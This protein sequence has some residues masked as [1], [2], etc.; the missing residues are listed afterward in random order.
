MLRRWFL[1]RHRLHRQWGGQGAGQG[2]RLTLRDHPHDKKKKKNVS[3]SSK[4]GVIF[5]LHFFFFCREGRPKQHGKQRMDID[6]F[7]PILYSNSST[8]TMNGLLIV[9]YTIVI[10]VVSRVYVLYC[11][12][13][14]ALCFV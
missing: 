3:G 8:C 11:V 2:A 13:V 12:C 7:I 14:R 5:L 1:P 10:L 6:I 9:L 4:H